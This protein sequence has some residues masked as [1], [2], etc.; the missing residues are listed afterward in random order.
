MLKSAI[1]QVKMR[2]MTISV[3][4]PVLGVALYNRNHP[5]LWGEN[6]IKSNDQ[7]IEYI[8][9]H[10]S[11]KYVVMGS[12]FSQYVGEANLMLRSG[13]ITRGKQV[14]KNAIID[15]IKT[16]K[17]L[18]V[19]PIIVS[20]PPKNGEN[21]PRCLLKSK[22][23]N[24]SLEICHMSR[25]QYEDYQDIINGLVHV[26]SNYAQVIWLDKVLCDAKV[27]KT[28]L[29][30]IIVFRD[31]E[32]FSYEGS[33]WIGKQINAQKYFPKLFELRKN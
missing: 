16:L 26:L 9:Q 3:C 24:F 28:Y 33:G 2:Q 15:T 20:P 17:Q 30:E 11:V 12:I 25:S 13:E 10:K 21:H 19:T 23:F 8:K 7:V 31:R 1:P 5:R 27:C 6:C 22:M 14:A 29:G 18:N 4:G 32:H